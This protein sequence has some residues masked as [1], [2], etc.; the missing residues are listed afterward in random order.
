MT[1]EIQRSGLDALILERMQKGQFEHGRN[2]HL[3]Q[4]T[5]NLYKCFQSVF[6]YHKQKL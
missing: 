1:I 3:R 5:R 2:R 4:S 6:F